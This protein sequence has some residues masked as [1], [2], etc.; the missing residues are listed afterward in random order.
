MKKSLLSILMV[1]GLLWASPVWANTGETTLPETSKKAALYKISAD[2]D[3]RT[4]RTQA[5]IEGYEKAL[6]L[7]PGLEAAYFNLAIAHYTERNIPQAAD[8][9]EKLLRISP[10]DA[11][12]HYNLACLQ[13]YQQDVS[14]ATGRLEHALKC[15]QPNSPLW[16]QIA[17]C[18][19]FVKQ[20]KT[21]DPPAQA[22]VFALLQKGLD[23]MPLP[24]RQAN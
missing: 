20:L 23:P 12:A 15:C 11:E 4:G 22:A 10:N 8:A 6:A 18:L 19:T 13:I 9:L 7:N 16:E 3:L 5:S 24:S 2:K 14:N 1:G 21:L 17:G